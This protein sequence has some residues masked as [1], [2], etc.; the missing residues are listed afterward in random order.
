VNNIGRFG[1]CSSAEL[2]KYY[3]APSHLLAPEAPAHRIDR[4]K[5]VGKLPISHAI[6]RQ[7]IT[8]PP[9]PLCPQLRI[10]WCISASEVIG[11]EPPIG[12]AVCDEHHV[13]DAQC[14]R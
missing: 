12:T 1:V 3:A 7:Q 14:F 6:S 10:N 11:Q 13:K 9:C 2:T 5:L 8:G 4:Q